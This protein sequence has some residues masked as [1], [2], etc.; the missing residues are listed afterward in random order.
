MLSCIPCLNIFNVIYTH[1]LTKLHLQYYTV[2]STGLGTSTAK[3]AREYFSE[4]DRHRIPFKYAGSEDDLA[5]ILVCGAV[6]RV[7]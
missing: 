4:M 2:N 7:V 5:I 1:W 3:E 6:V